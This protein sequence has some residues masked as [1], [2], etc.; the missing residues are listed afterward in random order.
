MTAETARKATFE[1]WRSH[2]PTSYN[3][4]DIIFKAVQQRKEYCELEK[5]KLTKYDMKELKLN[6]YKISNCSYN[7]NLLFIEW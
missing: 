6:G 2:R 3:I 4:W 5:D 1:G 7:D